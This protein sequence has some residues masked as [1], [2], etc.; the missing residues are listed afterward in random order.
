MYAMG[1]YTP[2]F[3]SSACDVCN[4]IICVVVYNIYMDIVAGRVRVYTGLF[5]AYGSYISCSYRV[6][7]VK[8]E[9]I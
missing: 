4:S 8:V 1:L 2:S 6:G 5:F 3:N 9:E 7:L